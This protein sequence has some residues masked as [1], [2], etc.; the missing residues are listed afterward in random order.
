[1][2]TIFDKLKWMNPNPILVNI[3]FLN[4][5]HS[6]EPKA[7]KLDTSM[8]LEKIREVLSQCENGESIMKFDMYFCNSGGSNVIRRSEEAIICLSDIL[9]DSDNLWIK[10]SEKLE[11]VMPR[12]IK[13]KKLDCGIR[14]TENGPEQSDNIA[15]K[16]NRY[17]FGTH[18]P[19][20]RCSFEK[21]DKRLCKNGIEWELDLNMSW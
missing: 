21:S 18:Y 6:E 1:M 7:T 2:D 5:P 12:L 13:E 10:R 4:C 17:E 11:E 16:F 9:G 20:Y 3:N 19:E 15:F 8:T 14:W